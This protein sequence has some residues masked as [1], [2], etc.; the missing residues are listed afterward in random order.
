LLPL[1]LLLMQQH[2]HLMLMEL[3]EL[4]LLDL[5]QLALLLLVPQL[6]RRRLWRVQSFEGVIVE[7]DGREEL[8]VERHSST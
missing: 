1:E 7:R 3:T 8:V 6:Q 5:Q 4:L 2:L